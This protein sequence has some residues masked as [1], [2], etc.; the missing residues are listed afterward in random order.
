MGGMLGYISEIIQNFLDSQGRSLYRQEQKANTIL[1]SPN[2]HF[3]H[4]L[5]FLSKHCQHKAYT[6]PLRR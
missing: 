5:R 3:N 2:Q 4:L 1:N 6:V